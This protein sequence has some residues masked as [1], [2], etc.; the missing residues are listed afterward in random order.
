MLNG[1]F[2]IEQNIERFHSRL[3]SEEDSKARGLLLRLL[4]AETDK[5]EDS[6]VSDPKR[7]E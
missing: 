5:L 3:Q 7:V 2:V 1:R 4:I 6:L